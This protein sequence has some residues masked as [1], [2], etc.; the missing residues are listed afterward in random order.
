MVDDFVKFSRAFN[1]YLGRISELKKKP[2]DYPQDIPQRSALLNT[3]I[4]FESELD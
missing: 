1:N 3:G 4:F 2:V